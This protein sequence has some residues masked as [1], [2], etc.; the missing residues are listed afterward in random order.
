R[1]VEL[2]AP[3]RVALDIVRL[4]EP[5]RLPVDE[6]LFSAFGID[7]VDPLFARRI[8][9]GD[10]AVFVEASQSSRAAFR[11][12]Q[13]AIRQRDRPLGSIELV[14]DQLD[15]C[16]SGVV[17]AAGHEPG[18]AKKLGPPFLRYV[19]AVRYRRATAALGIVMKLSA[20]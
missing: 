13:R 19:Y 10:Q 3:L 16:S 2:H 14:G 9:V 20:A 11:E 6:R 12:E 8:V 17:E 4:I 15:R 5:R 1:W 7:D 18:V